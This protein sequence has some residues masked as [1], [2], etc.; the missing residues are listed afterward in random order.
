MVEYKIIKIPASKYK[1]DVY[2]NFGKNITKAIFCWIL[3]PIF[4]LLLIIGGIL[5]ALLIF[6]I[7]KY[8]NDLESINKCNEIIN[9][10]SN[11][12]YNYTI[13]ET[14]PLYTLLIAPIIFTKMNDIIKIIGCDINIIYNRDCEKN[15]T[16]PNYYLCYKKYNNDNINFLNISNILYP[17]DNVVYVSEQIN[18]S[19]HNDSIIIFGILLGFIGILIITTFILLCKCA[20]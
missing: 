20:C 12:T 1:T 6:N 19:I 14:Q 7:Y 8:N 16:M 9:I 3:V 15:Y 17:F 5:S 4:I 10:A 11:I 13:F 2:Q 18:K